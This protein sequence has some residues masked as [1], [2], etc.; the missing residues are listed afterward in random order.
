MKSDILN[1]KEKNFFQKVSSEM[2]NYVATSSLGTLSEYLYRYYGKK[3]IILLDEYDTPMQ[4][5]YVNDYW[6]ELVL[7]MK[8]LFNATFKTNSYLERAIMTGITRVSKESIFSDLNNLEVVTTTSGKYAE[9]FGFTQE[10]VWHALQEYG[11]YTER[12]SKGMV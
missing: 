12:D 7:F 6:D 2:K 4:E 8:G 5:A 10:E 9:A 3:V 1:E 11:L